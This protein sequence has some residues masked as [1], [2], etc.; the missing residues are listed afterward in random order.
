MWSTDIE[1][2]QLTLTNSLF[3]TVHPVY[4]RRVWAH[5]LRILHPTDGS[6]PN[7]DGIDPDSTSDVLIKNC[8]IRTGDDAIAI[9]S[10][11]GEFG[12]EFNISSSNITIRN[13][14]FGSPCCAV[15]EWSLRNKAHKQSKHRGAAC[16]PAPPQLQLPLAPLL[17]SGCTSA[18][19]LIAVEGSK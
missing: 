2:S 7:T 9:K 3:W 14:I 15:C 13:S 11:W 17:L 12:Y 1:I 16:T 8:Y 4:S 18:P 5:S 19:P 6:A 10:G